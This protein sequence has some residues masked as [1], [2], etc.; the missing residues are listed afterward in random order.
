MSQ[1]FKPTP[2]DIH[3][4]QTI[5]RAINR[6]AYHGG[7]GLRGSGKALGTMDRLLESFGVGPDDH[8]VL[9]PDDPLCALKKDSC[10]CPDSSNCLYC[11]RMYPCDCAGC[12]SSPLYSPYPG[13]Q[14]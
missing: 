2:T 10:K 9:E 5:R 4:L 6:T 7:L 8:G 12:P 14:P 13:Q 3:N 11:S 1:P